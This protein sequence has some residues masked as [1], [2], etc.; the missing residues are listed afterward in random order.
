MTQESQAAKTGPE[1]LNRRDLLVAGAGAAL[2]A[3]TLTSTS[4]SALAHGPDGEILY[5]PF[6][7]VEI[8]RPETFITDHFTDGVHPPKM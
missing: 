2:T 3:A 5:Q 8:P 1:K 4:Q 7:G 6:Q